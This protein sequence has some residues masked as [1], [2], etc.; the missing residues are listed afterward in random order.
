MIET[1]MDGTDAGRT[2]DKNK[3]EQVRAG[4]DTGKYAE[5]KY[6]L[7]VFMVMNCKDSIFV[8]N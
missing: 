4:Y 7:Q 3:E 1:V 5:I 6:W 2:S 8:M